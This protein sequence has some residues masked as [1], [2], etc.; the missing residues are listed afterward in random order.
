[1]YP[2]LVSNWFSRLILS[3]LIGSGALTFALTCR[4]HAALN[5]C[6][7]LCE[8]TLLTQTQVVSV[9]EHAAVTTTILAPSAC[10]MGVP[11]NGCSV[12]YS[13]PFWVVPGHSEPFWPVLGH[14]GPFAIL[15]HSGQSWSTVGHSFVFGII[16]SLS[17]SFWAMHLG[18]DRSV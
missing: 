10:G 6:T 7:E 9:F 5:Q 1:M 4:T 13:E 18:R 17:D 15:K 16:L 14:C 2:A 11:R 3:R 12:G 8:H